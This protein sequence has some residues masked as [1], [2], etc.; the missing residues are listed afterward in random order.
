MRNIPNDNLAYPVMIV[1]N[2]GSTGS[3]FLLNTGDALFFVTAKHVVFNDAG[4]INGIS[5][6]LICQT[7]NIDDD[8]ST[9]LSIDFVTLQANGNVLS[10]ADKDVAVVK[11]STITK[12]PNENSYINNL[13]NGVTISQ[14]GASE[15]ISVSAQNNVKGIDDVLISND[16]FLYGYPSSLGLRQLPQ[17]DYS[18]PL[19]RKGIVAN[20]YKSFGTIILDCPVYPGNSGGPVVQVSVEGLNIK[21]SVI[22]VVSQF[23]PYSENWINQSNGL[24]HTEISNS[25]YSVAVA[26]DFVFEIVG[27]T[28]NVAIILYLIT[29]LAMYMI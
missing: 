5:A 25:G 10:H 24:I 26:M 19:L 29:P 23:V 8:S 21:H 16:I 13:V 6:T 9:N 11:I 7:K 27:F 14:Q 18:K 12:L 4:N 3:G 22:G 2:T 15:I 28:P 1:I 17:F 20:V